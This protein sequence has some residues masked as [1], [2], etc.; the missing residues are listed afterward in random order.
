MKGAEPSRILFRFTTFRRILR[1]DRAEDEVKNL[2][3]L[4]GLRPGQGSGIES[5]RTLEQG[6]AASALPG[7]DRQRGQQDQCETRHG[8]EHANIPR[9][10]EYGHF[11]RRAPDDP[12]SML[13]ISQR[14]LHQINFPKVLTED[15]C[16]CPA[17]IG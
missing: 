11:V 2:Q 8:A 4:Q 10:V 12:A 13:I 17:L 3:I 7:K 16:P 5:L 15:K 6:V 1:S 14:F 9:P